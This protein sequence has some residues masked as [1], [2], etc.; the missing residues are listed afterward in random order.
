M[1]LH[2]ITYTLMCIFAEGDDRRPGQRH[3]VLQH[4]RDLRRRGVP[5]LERAGTNCIKK[6]LSGKVILSKRKGLGGSPILLKIVS[7][8]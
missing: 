4:R 3:G 7:E 1:E 8:N 6:A 5:P 2:H